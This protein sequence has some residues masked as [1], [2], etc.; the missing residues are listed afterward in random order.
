[1]RGKKLHVINIGGSE[2]GWVINKRE[3][4]LPGLHDQVL[5]CPPGLHIVMDYIEFPFNLL[6]S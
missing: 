1:M 4:G 3:F 2:Y 5:R 6:C